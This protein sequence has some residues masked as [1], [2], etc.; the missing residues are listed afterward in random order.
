MKKREY[1]YTAREIV[2][3]QHRLKSLIAILRLPGFEDVAEPEAAPAS[4]EVPARAYRTFG[5]RTPPGGR[6]PNCP[7]CGDIMVISK[8]AD[9]DGVRRPYCVACWKAKRDGGR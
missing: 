7:D 3:I 2:E 1:V 6:M 9:D 8:Y 4:A 5:T